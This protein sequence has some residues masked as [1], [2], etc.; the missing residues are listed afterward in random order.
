MRATAAA[1]DYSSRVVVAPAANKHLGV[2][3]HEFHLTVLAVARADDGLAV[4]TLRVSKHWFR[5]QAA[6]QLLSPT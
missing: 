5:S 3:A 4:S 1:S 6:V 2:D